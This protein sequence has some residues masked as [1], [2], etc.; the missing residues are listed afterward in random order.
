MID[1]QKLIFI[2]FRYHLI[3]HIELASKNL[4]EDELAKIYFYRIRNLLSVS[5]NIEEE[6]D[7][8]LKASNQN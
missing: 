8:K 4:V 3:H 1:I 6:I 2:T 7:Y 5:S